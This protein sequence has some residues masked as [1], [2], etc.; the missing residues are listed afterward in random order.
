MSNNS[1]DQTSTEATFSYSEVSSY[2]LEN[3][4]M[5]ESIGGDVTEVMDRL[6]RDL[7]RKQQSVQ[8]A[9]EELTEDDVDTVSVYTV[10]RDLDRILQKRDDFRNGVRD[11]LEDYNEHL[12]IAAQN[13]WKAAISTLNTEVKNHA[14]NIR[15]KAHSIC[16]PSKPMSEFERAQLDIQQRQLDIMQATTSQ[17][18]DSS[19]IHKQGEKSNILALA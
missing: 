7:R 3:T 2:T 6:S 11:F 17:T 14:K 1:G 9:I 19:A 12:E 4:M 15:T 18:H 8:D 13:T 16:P 10:D 5:S